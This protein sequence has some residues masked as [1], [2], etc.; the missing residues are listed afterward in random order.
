MKVK[1]LRLKRQ[2]T[3]KKEKEKGKK[4]NIKQVDYGLALLKMCLEFL[5]VCA[6]NLNRNTIKI[7]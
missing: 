2:K 5:V 6:Q 7:K 3:Q 1:Y 4:I